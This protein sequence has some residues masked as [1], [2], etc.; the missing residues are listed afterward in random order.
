MIKKNQ[1]HLIHRPIF[2]IEVEDKQQFRRISNEISALFYKNLLEELELVLD[3]FSTPQQLIRFNRLEIDLGYIEEEA[4]KQKLL[5]DLPQQI[6]KLLAEKFTKHHLHQAH[7]F[8]SK[9]PKPFIWSETHG[10]KY[11]SAEIIAQQTGTS[12]AAVQA[13]AAV[14][15]ISIYK[16]KTT[17]LMWFLEKG[18]LPDWAVLEEGQSIQELLEELLA[19]QP[20]TLVKHFQQHIQKT[21]VAQRLVQQF[22]QK[23]LQK[24]AQLV[25]IEP[26]RIVKP[27]LAILKKIEETQKLAFHPQ[28]S[29]E[30]LYEI[31]LKK[32]F[33][34]NFQ[35]QEK[36][37][38][39]ASVASFL[40]LYTID[41]AQRDAFLKREVDKSFSA[42]SS[43][44]EKT[45]ESTTDEKIEHP[46]QK[47]LM[48]LM[49]FLEKGHLPD[50][51]LL[52][53]EQAARQLMDELIQQQPKVLIQQLQKRIQQPKVVQRLL[54]QFSSQQLE[55]LIQLSSISTTP[56]LAPLITALEAIPTE[57]PSA[58]QS[59][60]LP[61]TREERLEIDPILEE[62]DVEESNITQAH[63]QSDRSANEA[64]I[65]QL[66]FLYAIFSTGKIPW[67]ASQ[68]EE[69]TLETIL[70][71]LLQ[72][73]PEKITGL[74]QNLFKEKNK[75]WASIG[76]I[77]QHLSYPTLEQ[78]TALLAPQMAGF[79]ITQTLAL[80]RFGREQEIQLPVPN[81]TEPKAKAWAIALTWWWEHEQAP[82]DA[83]SFLSFSISQLARYSQLVVKTTIQR[84][85][86]VSEKAVKEGLSRFSPLLMFL[87]VGN[88]EERI[89]EM[90][91]DNERKEKKG[92]EVEKIKEE[93]LDSTIDATDIEQ[94]STK[95]G[96]KIE[97]VKKEDLDVK[98]DAT[99][100][101]QDLFDS[102]EKEQEVAEKAVPFDIKTTTKTEREKEGAS[103]PLE[104]T[105]ATDK[106]PKV[107][108]EAEKLSSQK[109][110]SQSQEEETPIDEQKT[111]TEATKTT[112]Q[113]KQTLK[114]LGLKGQKEKDDKKLNIEKPHEPKQT[115]KKTSTSLDTK[116]AKTPTDEES[117]KTKS[118]QK[119]KSE[120]ET[121]PIAAKEKEK[122]ILE[123]DQTTS[124]S[125]SKSTLAETSIPSTTTPDSADS[126]KTST[127][128]LFSDEDKIPAPKPSK[129]ME[130][131][132]KEEKDIGQQ[133]TPSKEAQRPNV[134]TEQEIT[135]DVE[136]S[137]GIEKIDKP[138]TTAAPPQ[139]PQAEIS[140][141]EKDRP[142]SP[143]K[144]P[145]GEKLQADDVLKREGMDDLKDLTLQEK[146]NLEQ[147]EPTDDVDKAKKEKLSKK[148][149]I[150]E[151]KASIKA[152]KTDVDKT[153]ESLTPKDK[154][155]Q[156]EADLS[157][158][159]VAKPIDDPIRPTEKP[160]VD[161]KVGKTDLDLMAYFFQ[162]GSLPATAEYSLEE[163]EALLEQAFIQQPRQSIR[164]LQ[165]HKKAWLEHRAIAEFSDNWLKTVITILM[166][167]QFK[168]IEDLFSS[169]KE[170]ESFDIKTLRLYTL[171]YATRLKEINV[172]MLSYLKDFIR[173]LV[174][175]ERIDALT[176]LEKAITALEA[177]PQPTSTQADIQQ[178]LMAL[179]K[180]IG[181]RPPAP[182]IRKAAPKEVK[183]T[184][185][186]SYPLYKKKGEI[187]SDPIYV[188]NAGLVL[189][190]PFLS[191]FFQRLTLMNPLRKFSSEE[192]QLRAVH[193]LQY[194]ATKHAKTPEHD[195]VLN[196][197]LCG[198]DIEQP[199]PLEIEMKQEEI[200]L[201]ESLLKAAINQWTALK[202]TSPD[203]L[204]GA[205][206]IRDGKLNQVSEKK[207]LLRVDQ[208]PFDV[209][210]LKIP[211]S[212][213]MIRLVWTDY[214]INVEW[215]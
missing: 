52:D 10:R 111:E 209:L 7:F 15:A 103:T 104:E 106:L 135:N 41:I 191:T 47:K 125:P 76:Y 62:K 18:R 17:T 96:E 153:G 6:R 193:L 148:V 200:D 44:K 188:S 197:L 143:E 208:R 150:D 88:L 34:T 36:Q 93:D 181:T 198:I 212:Y 195:L 165:E 51:T 146:T 108:E 40:D 86:T 26:Q 207:W 38:L 70:L 182:V 77:L 133:Q 201:S 190:W 49:A 68:Q 159:A 66:D 118:I 203:G 91:E 167:N 37:L 67:W 85:Q 92:E 35:N 90:A 196:K 158:K 130:Q 20:E 115:D 45:D 186:T 80:E 19:E 151:Q 48:D 122:A 192:A 163:F 137:Q 164:R 175:T 178:Y 171:E 110:S 46:P 59:S 183:P 128:S 184:E 162:Y 114:T 105:M 174:R 78:L 157:K 206:L 2:Q 210:L 199:L 14:S 112:A 170:I 30:Q 69:E 177:L 109:E 55:Q 166:P 1:N 129:M 172:D 23:Q 131:K 187:L 179:K 126:T 24:I 4:L 113:E 215:R 71:Q 87:K 142:I 63:H 156:T 139:P 39:E 89:Q 161:T 205:F 43:Q 121:L 73:Q 160:L 136:Q 155:S 82:L 65:A 79:M 13:E 42:F 50:W 127:K 94:K 185:P 144:E 98:T 168:R 101:Q 31:L 57:A 107:E 29:K 75:Q 22:S 211:W 145:Y 64:I 102:K 119:E 189:L 8:S 32:V 140:K 116:E 53:E 61:T 120:I 123:K 5:Q 99:N 180:T 9:K 33:T 214:I 97:K 72:Q 202:N 54:E 138:P 83:N 95:V 173:Y 176:F 194:L 152:Q 27:F 147:L 84:I 16:A 134:K 21:F 141:T 60:P 117:P 74:F 213:A 12:V 154:I 132:Q 25:N 100:K 204:R 3:E 58:A 149:P 11:V 81:L 56:P 28:K 169:L 124:P